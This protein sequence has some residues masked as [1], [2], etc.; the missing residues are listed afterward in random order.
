MKPPRLLHSVAEPVRATGEYATST[1]LMPLVS[2]LPAGDGHP[3]L[4]LPGFT[5][6]DASTRR[7]R[8]VLSSLGYDAHPWDLGRNLGPTPQVVNGLPILLQK[9]V[10]HAGQR[11]S[12]V[13]WSL[14]G[15]FARDLA[16]R[17]S[18]LVRQVVTLGSPVRNEVQGA[19]R[20]SALF[21]ALR[22]RHVAGHAL[23][24][25]GVPLE[26]PVTA[27]HTRSDG[28]VHWETCLVQEAP[29]SENLR[30]RGSHIGLGYNPAVLY[31]IADRLSLPEHG[32]KPFR[33]PMPYRRIITTEVRT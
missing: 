9:V 21:D 3:V 15:A 13:G 24:D 16:A 27:I 11:A 31:V 33:P 6:S 28:I 23:L 1:G 7:L 8:R 29:N 19:S 17:H 26:V 22:S 14:G 32:W 18:H 12:L 5:A 25:D 30:V 2:L 20:A 10:R 4:V